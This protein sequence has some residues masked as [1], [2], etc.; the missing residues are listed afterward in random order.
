MMKTPNDIR[1]LTALQEDASLSIES[2][3]ERTG[4]ARNTCWR[5]L[6]QLEESGIIK[7]RVAIL[8]AEKAG[9]GLSVL[10]FIRTRDHDVAWFER[11]KEAV[12]PMPEV[13]SFY[14]TSGDVDYVL[15]ARVFDVKAYDRLYQKLIKKV[16]LADVSASFIMEEVKEETAI[17]L[18]DY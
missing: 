8:D 13:V 7:G 12:V 16:A 2:L 4:I 14:R 1:I 15:R 18:L 5:R 9:C 6:K 3:S 17:P 10:I 11:L